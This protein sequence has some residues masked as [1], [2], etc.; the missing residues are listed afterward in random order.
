MERNGD[1]SKPTVGPQGRLTGI[2]RWALLTDILN[3]DSTG[4]KKSVLKWRK[5]WSDLKNNTKKKQARI[6]KDATTDGDAAGRLQLTDLEKRVLKI[7]GIRA[8]T[9]TPEFVEVEAAQEDIQPIL[10]K[11][12]SAQGDS[13]VLKDTEN[14]H[15]TRSQAGTSTSVQ[16]AQQSEDE[17]D[18]VESPPPMP[19]RGL[20]VRNFEDMTPIAEAPQTSTTL[21]ANPRRRRRL[22][23]AMPSFLRRTRPLTQSGLARQPASSDNEWRV[24]QRKC[25]RERLRLR[26]RELNQQ[27]RWLDLFGQFISLGN[28][29]VDLFENEH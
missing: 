26:E 25:E 7:V 29:V 18:E 12:S 16:P 27:D 6:Q 14:T 9:V 23:V 24:F 15:A 2:Q 21:P 22:R 8:G 17:E 1:L 11:A 20:R 5:V 19:R 4:D 10:I 28:R 13:E 3:A